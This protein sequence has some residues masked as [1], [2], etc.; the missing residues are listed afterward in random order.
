[1]F[2]S[3]RLLAICA[4]AV[5]G[6]LTV[7][8]LCAP[9][10]LPALWGVP[11]SEP[12]GLVSRRAAALFLGIGVMFLLARDAPPSRCRTALCAG[13]IVASSMLAVLGAFELATGNA[14]P[15]ILLAVLVEVLFAFAFLLRLYRE[16]GR[17]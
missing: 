15:G 4:A 6:V 16:N 3:F 8:G 12:V 10:L 17:D 11:Y 5:C 1:M 9:Q 14:G 7:L 2:P 13:F